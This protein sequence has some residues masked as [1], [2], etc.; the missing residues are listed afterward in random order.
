MTS[1][2]SIRVADATNRVSKYINHI[3][4]SPS[5]YAS[6]IEAEA[7]RLISETNGVTA[8]IAATWMFTL[9]QLIRESIKD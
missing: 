9:A 5:V 4:T 6:L 2:V 7:R 3:D 1:N 8:D